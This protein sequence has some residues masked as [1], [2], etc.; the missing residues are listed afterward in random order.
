MLF[1][2]FDV[3]H[4]IKTKNM[5]LEDYDGKIIDFNGNIWEEREIDTIA[6]ICSVESLKH[7][8]NKFYLKKTKESNYSNNTGVYLFLDGDSNVIYVGKTVNLRKRLNT[9]NHLPKE[10]YTEI[11]SV[12]FAETNN[13]ADAL[14]YEVYY[15]NKFNPKYNKISKT[16]DCTTINL[17]ELEFVEYNQKNIIEYIKV[18]KNLQDQ[19]KIILTT[20]EIL[21]YE[22]IIFDIQTSW[23]VKGFTSSFYYPVFLDCYDYVFSMIENPLICDIAYKIA[24]KYVDID[25]LSELPLDFNITEVLN[26]SILPH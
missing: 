8:D 19:Q 4:D 7:I 26:E 21:N 3:L 11:K 13:E 20:G 16:L 10:C 17:K 9:H 15:I 6:L 2:L 14:I 24:K 1:Y 18:E 22:D 25:V 12:R 23:F 5:Y